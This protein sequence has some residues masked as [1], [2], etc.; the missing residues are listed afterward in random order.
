METFTAGL[1]GIG[2]FQDDIIV[3]GSTI[4]EHNARLDN[5]LNVLSNAGLRVRLSKCKFIQKSIDYLDHRLDE[6]GLHT[7][8]KHPD[9]I[10]T[11]I[12]PENKT[13]LK[14]FLGLVTY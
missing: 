7:L 14:S 12:V 4:T 5:L 1:E 8:T 9:N 11:A 13:L 6:N 3:A 2:I 10:N